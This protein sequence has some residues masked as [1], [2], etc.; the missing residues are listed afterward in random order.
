MRN[1]FPN[2]ADADLGNFKTYALH[3]TPEVVVFSLCLE[4]VTDIEKFTIASKLVCE[5]QEDFSFGK[6]VFPTKSRKRVRR[7]YYK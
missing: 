4:L 7:A 6:P 2:V 3:L 1:F 5:K